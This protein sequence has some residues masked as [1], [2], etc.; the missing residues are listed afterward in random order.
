MCVWG[1]GG[2]R[3]RIE[4]AGRGGDG[5]VMWEVRGGGG[6]G[7]EGVGRE[8]SSVVEEGVGWGIM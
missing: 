5:G 6:G 2:G 1:G 3:E 8:Q 4:L 7:V